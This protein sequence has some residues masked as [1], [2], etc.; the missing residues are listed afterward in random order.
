VRRSSTRSLTSHLQF[1]HAQPLSESAAEVDYA[2]S[3]L[4][5]YAAEALRPTG[6]SVTEIRPGV[7]GILRREPVG[8]CVIITPFN[9][10]FAMVAR[11]VAA[12]VAAGCTCIV[13]PSPE[14]PLSSLVFAELG[15]R[16][17]LPGGVCNVVVCREKQTVTVVDKLLRAP[18]VRLVSFTGSSGVG[19]AICRTAAENMLRTSMELGSSGA[20]FIIFDDADVDAAVDALMV[21][22]F[23]A[24]GQSCIA[25]DRV[26]VQDGA[27][28]ARATLF[29]YQ[30]PNLQ[31]T[32]FPSS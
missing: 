29:N 10:P 1:E 19:A 4:E 14:T 27:F 6:T 5:W 32:W 21:A 13:K 18:P 28:T 31:A 7:S 30:R 9:F 11:K 20:P 25:A 2:V 23:R 22:K 26:L 15:R 17:G 12:A 3:Y 16:A 24:A 8:V